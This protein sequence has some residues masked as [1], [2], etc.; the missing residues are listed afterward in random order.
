M[1]KFAE[2]VTIQEDEHEFAYLKSL[3]KKRMGFNCDDYKQPHLKRRLAVRLRATQSRSYKEYAG[4]LMKDENEPPRLKETL[5][6]NVT[7]FFRNPETYEAFRREALPLLVKAR[8]GTKIIKAWSAGC[9]N[10]EELCSIAIMLLEFLG[11]SARKYNIQL[12]GTDIDDESL[13]KAKSGI[14]QPKILEKMSKERLDR[15]FIYKDACYQVK[16][17]IRGRVNFKRHDMISDPP[18]R[19]FDIIFCRNV[20]IYFDQKLQ[21]KL[22]LNFYNALN[23]NGFFVMG[24]TES[25]VGP[26]D[27]LFKPVDPR[28]RIYQKGR[29]L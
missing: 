16:D 5:T 8:E 21:E 29:K 1:M 10:G 17:E 15:F 13:E 18:L 3:I 14:Y 27:G 11:A 28:E 25:L 24:K 22:Y 7:E 19:G 2:P 9:S 6:I 20:T 26:A 12:L 4:I 23:D